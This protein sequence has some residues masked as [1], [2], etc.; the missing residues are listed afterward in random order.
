MAAGT[1][2]L[3][4]AARMGAT[5]DASSDLP[6]YELRLM[7]ADMNALNREVEEQNRF[8]DV[9]AAQASADSSGRPWQGCPSWPSLACS[10]A[11]RPCLGP[12]APAGPRS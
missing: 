12:I 8:I 6:T 1:R 5:P 11:S 7:T 2:L 3:D 4:I 10:S 9:A